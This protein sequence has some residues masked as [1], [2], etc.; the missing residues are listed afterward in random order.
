MTSNGLLNSEYIVSVVERLQT[1]LLTPNEDT[2][3]NEK[4]EEYTEILYIIF[5]ISH[6]ILSFT[7]NW[8]T[9]YKNVECIAGMSA[10]KNITNKVIFRHM[11][12]IDRLNE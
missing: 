10:R 1:L 5:T 7:C 11:D 4:Y 2:Y 6:D 8:E 3:I 12:I 9:I